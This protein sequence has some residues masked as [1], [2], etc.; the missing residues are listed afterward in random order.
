MAFTI[1]VLPNET[2]AS[3]LIIGSASA[4]YS[5][6][7]SSDNGWQLIIGANFM[8]YFVPIPART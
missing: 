6:K 5:E 8:I 2:L 4:S 7:S 3:D 1:L